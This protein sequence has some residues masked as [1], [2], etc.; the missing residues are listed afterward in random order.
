[1]AIFSW[2]VW[3]EMIGLPNWTLSLRRTRM[4]LDH[5]QALDQHALL[6]R[7][8]LQDLAG[9]AL[10]LAGE[11]D[12]AVALLDLRGHHSTSGASEMIFM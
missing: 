7:K 2:M 11:D 12:D 1:M 3:K 6:F 10:V 8:H 5:V 9:L 4:A